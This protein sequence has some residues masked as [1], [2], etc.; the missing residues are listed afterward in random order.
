M[1]TGAE[2][3]PRRPDLAKKPIWRALAGKTY[4]E[5]QDWY[6]KQREAAQ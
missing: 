6:D 5:I 2:I 3:Y 4:H 1:T